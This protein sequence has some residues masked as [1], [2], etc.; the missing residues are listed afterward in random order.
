MRNSILSTIFLQDHGNL[1]AETNFGLILAPFWIEF[2][3]CLSECIRIDQKSNILNIY[4]TQSIARASFDDFTPPPK[5]RNFHVFKIYHVYSGGMK[6]DFYI[7]FN[8]ISLLL[9]CF[10]FINRLCLFD[11]LLSSL[12]SPAGGRRRVLRTPLSR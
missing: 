10:F 5:I 12:V 6:V 7:I 1:L 8:V 9:Q 11:P 4:H 3:K 2:S